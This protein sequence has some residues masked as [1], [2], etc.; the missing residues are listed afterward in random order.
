MFIL[1]TGLRSDHKEFTGRIDPACSSSTSYRNWNDGNGHGTHVGS[2]AC[3]TTYGVANGCKM[4][5]VK[6][7]SDSGSGYRSDIIAGIN[8]V[9]SKCGTGNKCVANM[10]LGGPRSESYNTAVN[11]AVAKG[12]V[13]AVA[14]GN[15]DDDACN[16]SPGS[17]ASAITVGATTSTDG[18][19]SFTSYGSCVDVYAPGVSIKAAWKTSSTATA[20]ISG[21]SM[22]T[23]HVAGIAAGMLNSG[24]AAASVPDQLKNTY[25][26]KTNIDSRSSGIS[27]VTNMVSGC[28]GTSSPTKKPTAPPSKQP[29]KIPTQN[30]T[31][32]GY[33]HPPT[34]NPTAPPSK[35]P[36]KRPT[37]KPTSCRAK[38]LSCTST[39][40]SL[41]CSGK[42]SRNKC[43]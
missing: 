17:A 8:H 2:T 10:S 43:T 31:I 1:D 4:C 42:C 13:F 24:I 12:I 25:K 28:T 6:V 40:A 11:E 5:A 21:T 34:K 36:T 27:L 29:T 35:Q 23:P 16:Y 39:T 41:C 22:A 14:A 9:A 19:A 26:T 37:S 15:S 18:L 7:L 3:E 33:T 20:T 38:G 32:T 30:P